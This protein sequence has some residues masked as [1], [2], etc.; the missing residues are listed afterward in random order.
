MQKLLSLMRRHQSYL[1]VLFFTLLS[2]AMGF[3]R[4]VAIAY[5]FG[6]TSISDGILVGIAPGDVIFRHDLGWGIPMR[7]W[8]ELNQQII[9]KSSNIL[10]TRC[11]W[12]VVLRRYSFLLLVDAI[13]GIT[14]PGVTGE[15]YR[16]ATY[17]VKFSAL[18]AGVICIY[19]WF[20]GVRYLEQQFLRVSL[21]ELGPNIGILA[22][23]LVLF[24]FYGVLGIA[25]WD[26][27]GLSHSVGGGI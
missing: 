5:M 13:I 9:I 21:S 27:F 17:L 18:S 19:Y 7:R 6:A 2:H 20:R 25:T 26:H 4:E 15:G 1:I 12:P 3:G 22:G 23:V 11:W 10:Y 14:A 24:H 16:L 8:H